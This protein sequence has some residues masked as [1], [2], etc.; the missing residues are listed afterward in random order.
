MTKHL[1]ALIVLTIAILFTL[2]F[3]HTGLINFVHLHSWIIDLLSKIFAGGHTGSLIKQTLAILLVPLGL[4]GVL[5]GG[6]WIF[7]RQA[8]PYL[9]HII[10]ISWIILTTA[11]IYR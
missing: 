5:G 10:W 1:L 6:Y 4:G 9:L 2:P 7:K 3:L 11:I 8:M